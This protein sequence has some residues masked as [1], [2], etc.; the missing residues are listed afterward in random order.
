MYYNILPD[1]T[2]TECGHLIAA[3]YSFIDPESMRGWVGMTLAVPRT[4]REGKMIKPL[5]SHTNS[6]ACNNHS[7]LDHVILVWLDFRFSRTESIPLRLDRRDVGLCSCPGVSSSSFSK[8]WISSV[9]FVL[10]GSSSVSSG[11]WDVS[12]CTALYSILFRFPFPPFP[13]PVSDS[14]TAIIFV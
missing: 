8:C 2:T 12:A 11:S 6:Y 4:W 1:D 3:C 5:Y 9:T 10:L 7:P 14:I 13:F